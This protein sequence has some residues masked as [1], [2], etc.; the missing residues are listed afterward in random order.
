MKIGAGF[1]VAVV[2]LLGA[3]LALAQEGDA[4]AGQAIYDKQC[5]TCHG[6]DGTPKEAVA[7][8]LKVEIRHLGSQEVQARG[9]EEIRKIIVEGNGKM[10]PQGL[11]E[12]NATNVVAYVRTLS[13]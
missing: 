7:R 6:A 10:R 1:G 5:A 11:G 9:D 13:Q 2:F 3:H 8:M 4:K 12:K